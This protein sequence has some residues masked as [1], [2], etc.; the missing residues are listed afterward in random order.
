MTP[1]SGCGSEACR[2][3]RVCSSRSARRLRGGRSPRITDVGRPLPPTS[4]PAPAAFGDLLVRLWRRRP[5]RVAHRRAELGSQAAI[6]DRGQTTPPLRTFLN[7]KT[8]FS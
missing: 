3:P 5:R 8:S 1:H 4:T 2:R 7:C 6:M